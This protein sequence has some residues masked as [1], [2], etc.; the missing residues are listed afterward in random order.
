M[1]VYNV[2]KCVCVCVYSVRVCSMSICCYAVTMDVF[3]FVLSGEISPVR[4]EIDFRAPHYVAER[5]SQVGERG[6]DHIY[7]INR[8]P[9]LE[10]EEELHWAAT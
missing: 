3:V 4:N 7:C 6:Y 2:C 5:M 10:G 1:W 8:M 9:L